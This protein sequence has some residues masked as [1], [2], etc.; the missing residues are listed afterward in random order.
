MCPQNS[1]GCCEKCERRTNCYAESA[2]SVEQIYSQ[3]WKLETL[4]II[5]IKISEL[6]DINTCILFVL[7]KSMYLPERAMTQIPYAFKTFIR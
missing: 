3:I 4:A 5:L 7:C 1:L 6:V 2:Q